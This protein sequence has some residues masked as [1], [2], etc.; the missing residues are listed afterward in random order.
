MIFS[1]VSKTVSSDLVIFIAEVNFKNNLRLSVG[2]KI[3]TLQP[4]RVALMSFRYLFCEHI[5]KRENL[6]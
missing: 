5:D 3:R 4:K 1:C 2:S 6:L